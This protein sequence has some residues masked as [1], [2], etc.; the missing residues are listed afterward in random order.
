MSWW[1]FIHSSDIA[2]KEES[3]ISASAVLEWKKTQN[4]GEFK[5]YVV[6]Y[7]LSQLSTYWNVIRTN[8][9]QVSLQNIQPRREYTVRVLLLSN[10]TYIS[11]TFTLETGVG[12]FPLNVNSSED[13][14][15]D[16]ILIDPTAIRET[17]V[18]TSNLHTIF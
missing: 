4:L 10:V 1:L 7:K 12:K 13:I 2:T 18:R 17:V 15:L 16:Q 9:T 3:T 14:N 6:L 8:G 5:G 11:Q